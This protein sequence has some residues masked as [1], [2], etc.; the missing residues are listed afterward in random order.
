MNNIAQGQKPYN[1]ADDKVIGFTR[2]EGRSDVQET[3]QIIQII[4]F[5][6]E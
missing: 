4:A 2:H 5:P 3:L 1:K 6:T